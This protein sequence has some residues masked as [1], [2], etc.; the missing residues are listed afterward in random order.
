MDIVSV[1]VQ[2]SKKTS[3]GYS[4]QAVD[5]A[6]SWRDDDRHLNPLNP[7]SLMKFIVL[8][9]TVIAL[10]VIQGCGFTRTTASKPANSQ[11]NNSPVAQTEPAASTAN[12]PLH[13]EVVPS[14]TQ[15]EV[16]T[17]EMGS[18]ERQAI[19]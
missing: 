7:W 14:P 9:T 19:M 17:P 15:D 12:P 1:L 10:L 4:K 11:I 8:I 6:I 16:H 18:S 5:S 3:L 13:S 2:D